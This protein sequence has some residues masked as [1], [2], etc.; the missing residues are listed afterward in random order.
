VEGVLYEAVVGDSV[1]ALLPVVEDIVVVIEGVVAE[2]ILHTS[3]G[4]GQIF[5]LDKL[6]RPRISAKVYLDVFGG[7]V[8]FLLGYLTAV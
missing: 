1:V 4:V 7:F 6:C 5:V 3:M 8:S 2:D